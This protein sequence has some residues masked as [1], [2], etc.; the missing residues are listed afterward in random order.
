MG[1]RF[2][3]NPGAFDPDGDSLAYFFTTPK[4]D[5]DLDVNGYR[6]LI[7]A[8]FY[9]NPSA[10]NQAG[11]GVATLELDPG[12]GTMVWDSPGG[13]DIPDGD[14]REYNVAFVVEEWRFINGEWFRLGFVTRDMQIIVWNFDNEPP[15]IEVPEDTCVI[16]GETLTALITGTDADGDPVQLEAFGGPFEVTP[17]RATYSPDPPQFQGPPSVLT[18]EWETVCGHVRARPYEVQ[19]KATDSP[20]IPNVPDAPG[21]VNFETWEITVVGPSPTGLVANTQ[22]SRSI[23]LDWDPY[24]CSNADSMQV[25]RRVDEFDIDPSCEPGIPENSGYELVETVDISETSFLD[26]NDGIGLSPGSKYCYR[27][28][29]SFPE[30]AGGLSLV[31]EEACDSLL[32]DVPVITNVNTTATSET[33]GVLEIAWTPP[34]RLTPLL[35]HQV[36]PTRYY[37]QRGGGPEGTFTALSTS[38][39]DTFLIDTNLNTQDLFYAYKIVL[40]DNTGVAIDTSAVASSIRTS[41]MPQVGA[42][43]LNWEGNTP[44]SLS[45]QEHPY[46][47][48]FRD[49]VNNMDLSSIELI[50]SVDVT[51]DGL[52]YLDDGRFNG[53]DLDEEI[54]YCYYVSTQGSYGN[55][56][57]P[58]PLINLT[59]ITCAQP[60]DTI[61]PCTPI[62][63]TFDSSGPFSCENNSLTMDCDFNNF[64]NRLIWEEDE[65]ETC[66]DDIQLYRI[67]FS[68]SEDEESFVLLDETDDTSYIHGGLSSYAGCYRISAVDRSG[69]ESQQSEIFCNDNCPRIVLPNLFSPNG[70][71]VNDF[72]RPFYSGN[73]IGKDISNFSNLDCPRFVESIVFKVFNR[74]GATIFNYDSQE[75]ENDFLIN[76]DGTTAGGRE[77][78]SGV[79]FYSAEVTF[80]RLNPDDAV[81][82]YNGWVQILR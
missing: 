27:L 22:S 49:N 32:I 57:I 50:D 69:N 71:G 23:Q 25:W 18:F 77:L 48:I 43:R 28:V 67:Y 42:I 21:S 76:W 70:D 6:T 11:T 39:A 30:P 40:H 52:T 13:K 45:V 24:T 4:Q 16:A 74:A 62:A 73:L 29:A 7:D 46:H 5:K 79:Y 12:N 75:N 8:A 68:S 15:E 33:S 38:Q 60:N 10:G 31:S 82:V 56:L 9:D 59:Q 61:P 44:W 54:E 17:P 19:F 20:T 37:V 72:F 81:E 34:M 66:D 2:E 53:V 14:N 26:T 41:P 36:I 58:E 55:E 78:P 51:I 63:I 1:F 35:S 47:Y 64:Q 65:G 3:H 80:D